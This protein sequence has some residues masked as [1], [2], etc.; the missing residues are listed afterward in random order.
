MGSRISCGWGKDEVGGELG[1]NYK[2]LKPPTTTTIPG[3]QL[4][5]SLQKSGWWGGC[6]RKHSACGKIASCHQNQVHGTVFALH[7]MCWLWTQNARLLA[8]W[9]EIRLGHL[10]ILIVVQ[11]H[12]FFVCLLLPLVFCGMNPRKSPVP[13]LTPH[14]TLT[15]PS[16]PTITPALSLTNKTTIVSTSTSTTTSID[17]NCRG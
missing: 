8:G 14:T 15:T 12:T 3:L 4:P 13:T 9:L 1:I 2:P 17:N 6:I 5:G 16:T 7:E 11:V 10:M